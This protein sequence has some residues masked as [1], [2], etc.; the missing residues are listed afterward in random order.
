M[1]ND[2]YSLKEVIEQRFDEM[3]T[4]LIAIKE[5]VTKTNGRVSSLERSRAQLWGSIAMLTLLGGVII[6]LAIMAIDSK[7]KNGVDEALSA[8]EIKEND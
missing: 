8:Y 4:H 6:T 5:Q 7:I 2:T 1:H 3:G